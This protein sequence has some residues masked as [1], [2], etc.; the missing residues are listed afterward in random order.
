M[1]IQELIEY[2][3]KIEDTVPPGTEILISDGSTMRYLRQTEVT[4]TKDL[5][6]LPMKNLTQEKGPVLLIGPLVQVD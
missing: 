2:L 4:I 1:N 6:Y 5:E 3:L